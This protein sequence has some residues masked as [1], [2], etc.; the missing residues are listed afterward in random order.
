MENDSKPQKRGRKP[1]T[2]K[3]E[4]PLLENVIVDGV[5]TQFVLSDEIPEPEPEPEPILEEK[6]IDKFIQDLTKEIEN[7]K[8]EMKAVIE[9]IFE[10]LKEMI[11][12]IE[13]PK[14]EEEP[15]EYI[16]IE[17]ENDE[18]REEVIKEIKELVETVIEETVEIITEDAR[19]KVIEATETVIEQVVNK[20]L[21]IKSLLN[22]L[23]IISVRQDMQEK[24]GLTPELVKILQ[25][26]IQ[27]NSAF[28]FKIENS[29]KKILEDNKIDSDDVPEL[30]SLFS[31]VYELLFSLKL[32]AST[33]DISNICGE[34]I[35]LTFN[36]M[37]AESIITFESSGS[38]ETLKIFNALVDSSISL[39][40]L[41]KTIKFSN[42][43]CFFW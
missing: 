20:T 40:K 43:C 23:I 11:S 25:L 4:E 8:E 14:E 15:K 39:I 21:E 19:E 29:F 32:T 7:P 34:L 24:Y 31:A 2:A 10:E 13:E 18:K 12:V 27:T 42:K 33:I 1:K 22:L 5:E 41:S 28:F 30:M 38:E 9:E 37:L 3:M 35:K 16:K 6:T 36:I 26:I 17:F